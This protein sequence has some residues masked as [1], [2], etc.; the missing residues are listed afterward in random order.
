MSDIEAL[1]KQLGELIHENEVL[2]R[3]IKWLEFN[4]QRQHQTIQKLRLSNRIKRLIRTGGISAVKKVLSRVLPSKDTPQ[5]EYYDVVAYSGLFDTAYYEKQLAEMGLPIPADSINHYLTKGAMLGLQPNVEF[6]E[7]FYKSRYVDLP[8]NV[9]GFI[10][11]ILC[12]EKEGRLCNPEQNKY[13]QYIREVEPYI[14]P[15]TVPQEEVKFS[16]VVPIYNPDMLLLDKLVQCVQQQNYANW[17][18]ILVDDKSTNTDVTS[19]LQKLTSSPAIT[20]IHRATNGHISAATNTG[21]KASTGD[22]ILFVDQDDLLAP[23]CLSN[24]ARAIQ[25]QNYQLIYSDEDKL[26]SDSVRDDP[27]FKPEYNQTLLYSI[28]YLNHVTCVQKELLMEVG[29]LREG[30]EGSQDYDLILRCVARISPER[31]GHVPKVL[32]HWRAVEGST[33]LAF[34]EKSYP[35]E[36]GK[37]ALEEAASLLCNEPVSVTAG[38]GVSYKTNWPVD[39]SKLVSILIPT[40]DHREDLA[41][42]IDTLLAHTTQIPYEIIVCDNGSQEKETL[43]YLANLA[44]EHDTVRIL[45]CDYDFNYSRINNDAAKIAKGE[46]LL[47]LNN[48]VEITHDDWLFEMVRHIQRE[49]VGIVGCKL[50]Y[51]DD[52]IQHAGVTVGIQGVAGHTFKRMDNTEPGYMT[53]A[54]LE[55]EV[56]AVTAACMLVRREVYEELNGLDE[57]HFKVAFNDVDFCLRTRKAGYK[58]V[59]TPYSVL[60]HHE[61]KSRGDDNHPSRIK[62]F[63]YEVKQ[64]K[65]RWGDVLSNDPFFS[66]NFTYQQEQPTIKTHL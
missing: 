26:Y 57:D 15:A 60:Y 16:I 51:P 25:S 19:Y 41:R 14:L 9:L 30:Y 27:H 21:I 49:Q 56:T 6:D 42:T 64:M 12:G 52:T 32:Y 65:A 18:L 61:S 35:W 40:K 55:R 50:L 4:Q 11:Y 53:W 20:V 48:D 31:I 3:R 10:H 54:H 62:R 1:R 58:I 47:L 29:L 34:S 8:E 45:T 43:D 66:P 39:T 5:H 44:R 7:Q 23:F 13:K 37:R 24:L 22:Y 36:R 33:A 63:R 59:Y 17:E 2:K 38:Y 46:Y 28:N